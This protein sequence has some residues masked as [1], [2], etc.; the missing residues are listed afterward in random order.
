MSGAAGAGIAI[1]PALAAEFGGT[2]FKYLS[3][4]GKLTKTVG[5]IGSGI[6]KTGNNHV[7]VGFIGTKL[8]I[9]FE[10]ALEF[11]TVPEFEKD[12][13][14]SRKESFDIEMDKKSHLNFDVYRVKTVNATDVADTEMDVFT[15]EKFYGN[16]N[17]DNDYISRYFKTRD[18]KYAKSFVYRT[19]GG[20]T[21]RPYE[22]ERVTSFYRNGEVLDVATKKIENPKIRMDKQSVSGVPYGEPAR[23]KL[24]LANESESPE[25]VYPAL[26]LYLDDT[27]N[28]NGAVLKVDGYPVTW[29]GFSISIEPGHVTEKTLEVYAGNG[30]DYEGIKLGLKSEE[31][32]SCFDEVTFDVHFLRS[33][34]PVNIS[35]PGDKWV[36]NT[37]APHDKTGYHMPVT[38]DGFDK[39]QKNFDHIEFQYKESA[40][41][42]DYWVNICSFFADDSL[43]NLA[44]GVKEMIPMNGNIETQFY[45]EGEIFEKAYDLR[46][47]LFCRNGNDYITTSS[48]VLSG[49]KD[50][51]RP[52]LFGTPEPVN[53]TLHIGENIVFSFSEAIEHNYLDDMVRGKTQLLRQEC[54]HRDD[55]QA[56]G[57]RQRNAT[58]LP[59]TVRLRNAVHAYGRKVPEPIHTCRN[60]KFEERVHF[61]NSGQHQRLLA[62]GCCA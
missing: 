46:A 22:G 41:G 11:E 44:S 59:W 20:A 52:Q 60:R 13:S 48:K 29:D 8:E 57:Y 1:A 42:D 38:I 12:R 39:N 40:R 14:W 55:H 10:P 27:S 31:D 23:F 45:G 19:R 17:Y 9:E 25:N 51:R 35:N 50:T 16:V 61:H 36:M 56:R 5:G 18:F 33:A 37:D 6:A 2:L 3:S 26:N 49:I 32:T 47:V 30:F 4:I 24:Y 34:G 43:Y 58:L 15:S 53:G 62:C 7:E 21:C 54:D 28:P